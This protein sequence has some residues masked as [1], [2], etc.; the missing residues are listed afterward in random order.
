M[1]HRPEG[2]H[3]M[4]VS[5]LCFLNTVYQII[6]CYDNVQTS[7]FLQIINYIVLLSLQPDFYLF[8]HGFKL[9]LHRSKHVRNLCQQRGS[10]HS[11]EHGDQLAQIAE[12]AQE[13]RRTDEYTNGN[14]RRIVLFS[15][16]FTGEYKRNYT[17]S[18][19]LTSTT[20]SLLLIPVAYTHD[21]KQEI[22]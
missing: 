11:Y 9:E 3:T 4:H 21:G 19:A 2:L 13:Q 6:V 17:G 12:T 16:M 1:Q 15:L 5:T 14:C 7:N 10:N 20:Q 18:N 22:D 8:L